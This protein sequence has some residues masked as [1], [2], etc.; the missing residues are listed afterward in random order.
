MANG[1]KTANVATAQTV[2]QQIAA[3]QAANAKLAAQMAN[4][5][6][7]AQLAKLQKQNAALQTA[8][9]NG[10]KM[11]AKAI[12]PPRNAQS[13]TGQV[14]AA[15]QAYK[16]QHGHWPTKAQLLAGPCNGINAN[17]VGTQ[18]SHCKTYNA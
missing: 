18:L 11:P 8:L 9:A 2:A 16:A 6:Q 15:A 13:K 3:L 17:T 10:G 4:A 1:K 5:Q 7:M 12:S 14:W